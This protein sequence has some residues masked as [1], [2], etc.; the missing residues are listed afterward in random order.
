MVVSDYYL[1][2]RL[3]LMRSDT[4]PAACHVISLHCI[5]GHSQSA[6]I[7]RQNSHDTPEIDAGFDS[8][9]IARRLRRGRRVSSSCRFQQLRRQE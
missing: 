9:I 3:Q 6:G 2:R 8:Q 1:P 5:T 4:P 7:R